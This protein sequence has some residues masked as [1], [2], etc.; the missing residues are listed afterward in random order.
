MDSTL[1]TA[2]ALASAYPCFFCAYE[3]APTCPHGF[4]DA[5]RD[6]AVLQVLWTNYPGPLV[7]V[8]TGAVSG[9]DVLDIDAE[10]APAREWWAANRTRLPLTRAHRTRSGG[11][12]LLFHHAGGV[13]C[14]VGRIVRGIDVLGVG[15]IIV[16]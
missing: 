13:N 10:H 15:R 5:S 12:H 7:G 8:P 14:S 9:I 4:K 1:A 11:L 16:W 3:K 6:P 2:L